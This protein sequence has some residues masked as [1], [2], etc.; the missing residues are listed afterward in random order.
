MNKQFILSV[1]VLFI[2]TFAFGFLIHGV[3][4]GDDYKA[5][6]NLMRPEEEQMSLFHFM[7][8]AHLF[9]AIGLT[10]V[11]RMGRETDKDWKGQ[12]ARF[13]IAVALLAVIPTYM[14]YYVVQQTPEALAIKQISFETVGLV[15][16][17]MVT[18]FMNR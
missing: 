6:T 14:I 13:G 10:W 5:L 4:L 9:I 18:A 7:A 3:L 1:V 12:G 17:G 15:I 16:T 11:Y 8:L 2:V